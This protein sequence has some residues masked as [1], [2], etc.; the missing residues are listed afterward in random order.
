MLSPEML[1]LLR[2]W[3]KVRPRYEDRGVLPQERWLFPGRR[4]GQ[5]LSTRQLIRLFHQATAAAGIRKDVTLHALRH[6][7]ATHR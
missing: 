6:S 3:W 5:L 7:F 4:R 2:Q 1:A